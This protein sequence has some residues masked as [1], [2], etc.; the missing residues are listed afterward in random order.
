MRRNWTSLKGSMGRAFTEG[1]ERTDFDP[2][3]PAPAAPAAQKPPKCD[4][5]G[6]IGSVHI[7]RDGAKH[8]DFCLCG[9]RTK[10]VIATCEGCGDRFPLHRLKEIETDEGTVLVCESCIRH[11]EDDP[12]REAYERA[13]RS[14][15]WQR[16]GGGGL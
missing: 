12:D 13:E 6:D 15:E 1:M 5:S 11:P 3:K 16:R 7:F 8:G 14:E 2:P 10:Y 4:R 9:K